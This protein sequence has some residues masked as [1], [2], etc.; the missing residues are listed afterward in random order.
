MCYF[1]KYYKINVKWLGQCL[2][3]DNIDILENSVIKELLW[4]TFSH[5]I[6]VKLESFKNT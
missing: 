4:T 5:V 1:Y 2:Y 3:G 6:Y